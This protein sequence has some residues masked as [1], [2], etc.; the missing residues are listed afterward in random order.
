MASHQLHARVPTDWVDGVYALSAVA[1]LTPTYLYAHAFMCGLTVDSA[2]IRGTA[3]A[4]PSGGERIAF[5]VA[6]PAWTALTILRQRLI[7]IPFNELYQAVLRLGWEPV[8]DEHRTLLRR[9]TRASI[10]AATVIDQ[11]LDGGTRVMAVLRAHPLPQ[12][13]AAAFT[14]RGVVIAATQ[15]DYGL[16]FAVCPFC[17]RSAERQPTRPG[18]GVRPR[19]LT[20]TCE[21]LRRFGRV[22]PTPS[23]FLALCPLPVGGRPFAPARPTRAALRDIVRPE[24][25]SWATTMADLE[26]RF[27]SRRGATS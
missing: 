18:C 5:T 12:D 19:Q 24:I 14:R 15:A 27:M 20:V 25:V 7:G 22:A 13:V 21:G 10:P 8:F 9:D 4:V 6:P 17:G 11:R 1:A 2:V 3:T 16:T 23:Q 26:R